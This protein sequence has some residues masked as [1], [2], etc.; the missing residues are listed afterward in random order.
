MKLLSS[1]SG[2]VFKTNKNYWA[3]LGMAR[4]K[5]REGGNKKQCPSFLAIFY[6]ENDDDDERVSEREDETGAA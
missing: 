3:W 5:G 4:C 1:D 6:G 2:G